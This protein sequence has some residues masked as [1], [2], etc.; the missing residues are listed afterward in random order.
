[1]SAVV[2]GGGIVPKSNTQEQY[3]LLARYTHVVRIA[4]GT[5]DFMGLGAS[6]C[7]A[8]LTKLACVHE[9]HVLC[10]C[11]WTTGLCWSVYQHDLAVHVVCVLR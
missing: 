6:S 10:V 4:V 5:A 1:M 8:T 9:R 11:V 3:E 7:V 2:V